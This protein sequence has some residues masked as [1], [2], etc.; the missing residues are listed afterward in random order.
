[1]RFFAIKKLKPYIRKKQVSQDMLKI[2]NYPEIVV[3]KAIQHKNVMTIREIIQ[4]NKGY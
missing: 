3:M 4:E 1:V 2:E